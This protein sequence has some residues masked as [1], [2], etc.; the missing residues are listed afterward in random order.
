MKNLLFKSESLQGLVNRLLEVQEKLKSLSSVKKKLIAY[1]IG[2][3]GIILSIMLISNSISNNRNNFREVVSAMK[4]GIAALGSKLKSANSSFTT[5]SNSNNSKFAGDESDE[6][7]KKTSIDTSSKT[8][9]DNSEKEGS[10]QQVESL[11]ASTEERR[12][13]V[14]KSLGIDKGE[15][16]LAVF[17]ISCDF[18]DREA[19]NLNSKKSLDKIIA[20]SN[21]SKADTKKW[22]ESLGLKYRVESVSE[23][24]FDNSGAV[25]LPTIIHFIDGKAVGASET[26]SPI[27]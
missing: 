24:T 15:Y 8:G 5:D 27:N 22:Q 9:N 7:G 19:V 14:A 1:L 16:Y 26:A 12:K 3:L 23:L 18:C 6:S 25:F 2:V 13:K 17:S 4:P 11:L 10:W 21:A 20:I